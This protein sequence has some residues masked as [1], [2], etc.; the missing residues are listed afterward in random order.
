MLL[1]DKPKA[2][3]SHDVVDVVR[4]ATGERRVGHAGTLDPNATGLL[5][6]GVGRKETK[7]LEGVTKNARKTYI[8]DIFFRG[9]ERY[10]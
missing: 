3:T 4:K 7:T 6:I 9:G 2:M 1:V 5:I 8:A 10:R